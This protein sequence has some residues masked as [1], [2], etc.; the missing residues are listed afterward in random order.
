MPS[1]VAATGRAIASGRQ[2]HDQARN[3]DSLPGHR[4]NRESTN[5]RRIAL[6]HRQRLSRS[7]VLAA[8]DAMTS[9]RPTPQVFRAQDT[10]ARIVTTIAGV[11]RTA[12]G[13]GGAA[14]AAYLAY[15]GGVAV[16][17]A[18]NFYIADSD[19]YQVR[20]VNVA[21]GVISAVAGT[22]QFGYSGNG[23]LA[24]NAQIGYLS[25]L[26]VDAAGNL[27]LADQDYSVIRKVDGVTGIISVVA[28]VASQF[29]YSGDGGAATLA[30]LGDPTSV[31][32]DAAGNLYIADGDNY[33]IRKVSAATG[34]ITTVAGTP[35]GY[36]YSG[37]GGAA[38]QAEIGYVQAVAVD[39]AGNL[40]LA[41]TDD[42]VIRIVAAATG[43]INTYAGN[44]GYA[45][46]GD[47]GLA[48]N[49]GLGYP[50][51]VAADGQGNL[52]IADVDNNSIRRVDGATKIITTV[53]GNGTS[54]FAGDGGPA[55]QA[56][57]AYP[58]GV[59]VDA[60]GDLYI[61]DEGNNRIRQV[62]PSGTI[63]SVAGNG[64]LAPTNNGALANTVPLS[65]PSGVAVDASGNVFFVDAEGN[66]IR[67]VRAA[68]GTLATVVGTGQNGYTGDGGPAAS[69]ALNYPQNIAFN[70][71]GDLFIADGGNQVIR[72]VDHA[73]GVIT[74]VAGNGTYAYDNNGDG[75]PATSASLANPTALACDS[76]GNLYIAEQYPGYVRKVTPQGIISTVAGGRAV[77]QQQRRWRT[78]PPALTW[79]I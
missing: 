41:D 48:I 2:V 29:G 79:K 45:D 72:R 20:K 47:G 77:W 63:S 33:L 13:N 58:Y 27:Y 51:G 40:Y 43:I 30:N 54:G 42:S 74:T 23:Q 7:R 78:P 28:G 56:E 66:Q 75:G 65:Y 10:T 8:R 16:D 11:T 61:A 34:I 67:E 36:G 70:Q 62:N 15:P 55:T 76:T 68:D 3:A 71:Q 26:A 60:N 31:A 4:R 32:V 53:A 46:S 1:P 57:V 12:Y 39:A 35:Q 64:L 9:P 38:T 49:A 24:V 6:L 19:N 44:G 18:G 14:T 5:P 52:Y 25:G 37:D 59:A 21:T 17:A 69:A 73:S 22:G 50:Q